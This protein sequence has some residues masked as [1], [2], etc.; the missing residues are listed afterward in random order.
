MTAAITLTENNED[1]KRTAKHSLVE[2]ETEI[3]CKD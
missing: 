2:V 3:K 1:Q